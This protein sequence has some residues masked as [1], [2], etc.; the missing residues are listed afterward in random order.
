MRLSY[1]W[2]LIAMWPVP[3]LGNDS[4]RVFAPWSHGGDIAYVCADKNGYRI[5][6]REGSA[7]SLGSSALG[8]TSVREILERSGYELGYFYKVPLNGSLD[9][10]TQV[11]NRTGSLS[12]D[13]GAGRP[14]DLE[15]HLSNDSFTASREES[16][17]CSPSD[18]E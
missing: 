5:Y 8:T 16:D 11:L 15:N 6:P 14:T 7:F 9:S 13:I 3:V 1:V 18:F 4:I 2:I 12:C 10:N 17:C